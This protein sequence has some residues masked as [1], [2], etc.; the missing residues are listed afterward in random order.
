MGSCYWLRWTTISQADFPLEAAS[1]QL[2]STVWKSLNSQILSVPLLSRWGDRTL[3]FPT[4]PSS[5]MST[6]SLT[7]I[8]FISFGIFFLLSQVMLK[9]TI[10]IEVSYLWNYLSFG[11]IILI[12]Y[13]PPSTVFSYPEGFDISYLNISFVIL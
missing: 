11:E 3:E 13:F 1:H 5:L 8:Y 2:D 9:L 7:H 10:W 12:V 4:L 6:F